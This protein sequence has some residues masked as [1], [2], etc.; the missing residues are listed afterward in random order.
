ME[1]D[2]NR[3]LVTIGEPAS[4]DAE[5]QNVPPGRSIVV[6]GRVCAIQSRDVGFEQ[7]VRL[8]HGGE[9]PC[10]SRSL[11]VTYRRGPASA[12]EGILAPR[13]RTLVAD[14]ET[15]IVTRTDKS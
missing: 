5:V 4:L 12:A 3:K 15:F 10:D 13:Q 1:D 6:N 11:S 8:A 14:G 7:L 2:E 9:E